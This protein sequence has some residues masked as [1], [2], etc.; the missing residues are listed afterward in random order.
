[1]NRLHNVLQ[2][3]DV[4][5]AM[6]VFAV[7]KTRGITQVANLQLYGPAAVPPALP[8]HPINLTSDLDPCIGQI[9][10]QCCTLSSKLNG[11]RLD[12]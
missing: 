8:P 6:G 4:F 9:F 3:V 11:E 2:Y 10:R 7:S 5:L 12:D 1:M